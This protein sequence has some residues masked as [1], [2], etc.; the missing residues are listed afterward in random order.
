MAD[1]WVGVFTLAVLIGGISYVESSSLM[2]REFA[3][4]VPSML[5][6]AAGAVTASADANKLCPPPSSTE[7]YQYTENKAQWYPAKVAVGYIETETSGEPIMKTNLYRKSC[8]EK[9]EKAGI[10]IISHCRAQGQCHADRYEGEDGKMH[11]IQEVT[12]PKPDCGFSL[13]GCAG[14]GELQ[15][16]ATPPVVTPDQA[17]PPKA[18]G[19]PLMSSGGSLANTLKE[20]YKSTFGPAQPPSGADA[21]TGLNTTPPGVTPPVT[22]GSNNPPVIGSG[23]TTPIQTTPPQPTFTTNPALGQQQ[24]LGP[25]YNPTGGTGPLTGS[26]PGYYSPTLPY[27][28]TTFPGQYS[29]PGYQ[30]PG[31]QS[32]R[33]KYSGN[34]FVS[35]IGSF[36]S[37]FFSVTPAPIASFVQSYNNASEEQASNPSQNPKQRLV[38]GPGGV[39]YVVLMPQQPQPSVDEINRRIIAIATQGRRV[40]QG[41]VSLDTDTSGIATSAPASPL[42]PAYSVTTVGL[43]AAFSEPEKPGPTP[44]KATSAD[45]RAAASTTWDGRK[46]VEV[47]VPVDI[48]GPAGIAAIIAAFNGTWVPRSNTSFGDSAALAQ[49]QSDYASALAQISALQEARSAGLCDVTCSSSLASL[50][51]ELSMRQ[52]NIDALDETVRKNESALPDLP[53]PTRQIS[54]IV[55]DY[56]R[57]QNQIALNADIVS[58]GNAQNRGGTS[59][60]EPA[61]AS[62][63]NPPGPPTTVSV[64]SQEEA[65]PAPSDI[66]GEN[67]VVRIVSGIWNALKS[68]FSPSAATATS[69][70]QN[71]CSLFSRIFGGCK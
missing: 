15:K 7:V 16:P 14:A 48:G 22:T 8:S 28:Q 68:F 12:A 53:A 64:A 60:Q 21:L 11:D 3:V 45:T 23:N 34:G 44:K 63:Q 49:A 41:S 61:G 4:S 19:T 24:T 31:Y 59:T 58:S 55:D 35:L 54:R 67:I 33:P 20:A 57:S 29:S 42:G 56:V 13:V 10:Y 30:S 17:A 37:G 69:T 36:F 65:A 1:K 47:G 32:G 18:G 38:Q 2:S 27:N 51:S 40:P 6:Q 5:A 50:E 39:T 70:P 46:V 52:M 71:Y 43:E 66:T 9:D 26:S 62:A 25:G